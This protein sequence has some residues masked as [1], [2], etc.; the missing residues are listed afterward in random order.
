MLAQFDGVVAGAP[1][2]WPLMLDQGEFADARAARDQAEAECTAGRYG[3]GI[4]LIEG[5]LREIGVV[6]PPADD[7]RPDPP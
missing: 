7:G 6:P 1:S 3:F 5:A 4:P 2:A